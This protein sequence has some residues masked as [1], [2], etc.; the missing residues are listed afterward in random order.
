MSDE[1]N[2]AVDVLA[3][4]GSHY[5][6]GL[7][8]GKRLKL[9]KTF[10][11]QKRLTQDTDLKMAK[12][13]LME[14]APT[15]LE[16]LRGLADGSGV[17][18]T[19][20]IKMYSGYD[21]SFPQMGCTAFSEGSFYVR[22]YDFSPEFYDGRFVFSQP[23]QGYASAGFS[24]QMIGRLDGMNEKGLVIGLHLVNEQRSGVGFLGTTIVR[25]V[26]EQCAT[27]DEAVHLL[28][29]VTHGYCFNYSIMDKRGKTAIVEAS[30]DYQAV[31]SQTALLCTNHYETERLTMY[32]RSN[33]DRSIKR[34][35]Y[36]QDLAEEHLTPLTAYRNFNSE[37]S[38]LF[39]NNYREFFG[40]MHT[41]VYEPESLSIIVGVGR[42]AEPYQ[43][44]FKD[45]LKGTLKLPVSL[46]GWIK[47]G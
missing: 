17:D 21:F 3:L 24:Q 9:G 46:Q 44:S 37:E 35:G 42:N 18:F 31:R 41:I 33:I 10:E 4:K 12:A 26:L 11:Q 27:V 19:T 34:K 36:L 15:L 2:F 43:F 25:M 5:Q 40:T 6:I 22:N 30:P 13:S 32:N 39:F 16:E 14:V 1:F 23:A 47:H 8:Q 28:Q 7:E 20:I 29:H 45:W 38:P